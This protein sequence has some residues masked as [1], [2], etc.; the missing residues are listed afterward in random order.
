[1]NRALVYLI[2]PLN[3]ACIAACAR[4]IASCPD[5]TPIL[6]YPLI[7][8]IF[9][10]MSACVMVGPEL[11]G[12]ESEWQSLSMAY[13]NAAVSAPGK[14]KVSYPTW[15]YSLSQYTD[16]GVR[17]MFEI[18]TRASEILAPVLRA[19]IAAT[20]DL[21]ANAN[22]VSV[23]DGGGSGNR[24]KGRRQYE[25]GVQWLYDAHTARGKELTPVQL[26]RDLFVM[27]TASIHSTTG[28]GTSILFDLLAHPD[29]LEDIREEIVRVRSANPA[30]TRQ[31]LGDLR[32]LDSFMRES[33]RVHALTQ[34]IAVQ[35]IPT[36]SWTFKDGLTVPAGTTL[37]FPSYHHNYDPEVHADPG[38]FDPRR[39]LRKRE[40]AENTH[41][42]HFA[43]AATDMMNWGSGRHACPGRFFA[44]ETLKL[45]LVHLLMHYDFKHAEDMR[46]TPRF[47]SKNLFTVPNPTLPIMMRERKEPSP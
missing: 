15:L 39:H 40:E 20:V 25:D 8:K 9:A 6:P 37:A 7:M 23:G 24:I 41:K 36:E 1:M 18:Q 31:A 4:E 44:Q 38:S 13:V 47:I 43:S 33:A 10:G 27:M 34:Y 30:W 35:R 19:R 12:L 2:E 17:R 46:E 42:F 22:G 3:Q 5:W 28:A 29:V 21:K 45:M 14:V 26:A 11:G 16:K 32:L